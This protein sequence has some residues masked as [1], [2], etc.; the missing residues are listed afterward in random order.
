MKKYDEDG[1]LRSL[2]KHGVKLHTLGHLTAPKDT[3][4]GIRLWGK[5]DYLC[6]YCGY[7]FSWTKKK[8]NKGN[9]ITTAAN[10]TKTNKRDKAVGTLK[11]QS[12]L[13]RNKK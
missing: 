7:V 5:I 13:K 1:A 4:I 2:A 11:K 12:Q 6:H 9:A 8:G 10:T 3:I